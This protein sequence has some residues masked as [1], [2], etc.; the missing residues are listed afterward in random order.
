MRL[1]S[2]GG[3]DLLDWQMQ[4]VEWLPW[5]GLKDVVPYVSR[6]EQVCVHCKASHMAA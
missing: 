1:A 3:L 2:Q 4:R 5:A 6:Q